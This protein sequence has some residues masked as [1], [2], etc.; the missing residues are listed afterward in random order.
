MMP[1]VTVAVVAY[2]VPETLPA[3]IAAACASVDI[4]LQLVVVDN[5]CDAGLLDEVRAIGDMRVRI[6]GPALNRGFAG[7]CNLALVDATSDVVMLLNPDA[8]VEPTAI[9]ELAQVALQP[10]VG[11][12]TASLR[13]AGTP[14]R[15]NSAG[16]PVHYT[17]MTWSGSFDELA[18]NHPVARDAASA[19]GAACALRTDI[20]HGLGGFDEQAFAYLED[21]ELSL[22]CW[23]GGLSVRFVPN[24]VV[25]HSYEFSRHEL[26][27]YLL[28]RNRL[29]LVLTLYS[30]RTQLVLAPALV[31]FEVVMLV[32][33]LTARSL[34]A[35]LRGYGWLLRNAGAV[36]RRRRVV[37]AAR[38]RPDRDLVKLLE[39]RIEPGNIVVP[40]GMGA[41]NALLDA[42]WRG[43][44]RFI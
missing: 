36:S 25:V 37:Q 14:D 29:L 8:I 16:N 6:V 12:A 35:K 18:A 2:G 33:S 27:H 22:R 41:L 42:Y 11:I 44:R 9:A 24:A 15:L 13:L 1:S 34:R 26:K 31:L 40:P 3:C 21:T 20:W 10:D 28:E 19:T 30:R 43:A 32:Q 5:G 17:G 4:D 23:L 38:T 39:G 7:G